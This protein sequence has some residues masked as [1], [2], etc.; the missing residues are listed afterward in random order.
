MKKMPGKKFPSKKKVGKKVTK[1]TTGE[2]AKKPKVKRALSPAMRDLKARAER[3]RKRG[4]SYLTKEMMTGSD[5]I[6]MSTEAEIAEIT[7]KYTEGKKKVERPGKEYRVADAIWFKEDDNGDYTIHKTFKCTDEYD[8][9]GEQGTNYITVP[10]FGLLEKFVNEAEEEGYAYICIT[11]FHKSDPDD[12]KS[13][14]QCVTIPI[15]EDD[16]LVG[17]YIDAIGSK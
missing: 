8:S 12:K 11:N 10:H 2:G 6:M 9:D 7:I 1:K 17:E 4:R 15:E 16:A 5:M 13:Y 3:A 14:S